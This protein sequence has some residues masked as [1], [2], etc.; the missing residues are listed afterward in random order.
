[1]G[2]LIPCQLRDPL[3]LLIWG[4]K[5]M[6]ESPRVVIIYFFKIR[7]IYFQILTVTII[8]KSILMCISKIAVTF[9]KHEK[10]HHKK[11][12]NKTKYLMTFVIKKH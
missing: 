7:I 11:G 1:M 5:I 3:L 8:F 4:Q 12:K 9:K 10:N 2:T 6:Y